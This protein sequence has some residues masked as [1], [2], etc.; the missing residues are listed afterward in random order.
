MEE[1]DV[2][3]MKDADVIQDGLVKHVNYV[4]DDCS[5]FA[6]VVVPAPQAQ[7]EAHPCSDHGQLV[8]DIRECEI[9][10]IKS[11]KREMVDIDLSVKVNHVSVH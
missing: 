7:E 11:S 4:G 10:S 5:V 6:D 8:G 3:Q 9:L 2:I 1:E